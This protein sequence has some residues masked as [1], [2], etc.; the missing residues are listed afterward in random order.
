MTGLSFLKGREKV[1]KEGCKLPSGGKRKIERE[2]K[3][4]TSTERIKEECGENMSSLT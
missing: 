1:N 2:R 3:K 4:E